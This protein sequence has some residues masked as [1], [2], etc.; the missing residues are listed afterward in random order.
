MSPE[1]SRHDE[2][3][4][5]TGAAG[6]FARASETVVVEL[7]TPIAASE[8]LRALQCALPHP[9]RRRKWLAGPILRETAIDAPV[10]YSGSLEGYFL[11]RRDDVIEAAR[12]LAAY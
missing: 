5:L 9:C 7:R 3:A 1:P 4:E 6:L 8:P 12:Y 11:P 10:P 2:T